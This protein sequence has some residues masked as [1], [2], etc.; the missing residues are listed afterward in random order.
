MG[1][2]LQCFYWD[3]PRE[4]GKEYAWW[5]HLKA[6]MGEIA[7]AGF[8]SLWLPPAG[9]AANIGG[10]SM[11]YDVYD[12]FD[13]GKHPQKAVVPGEVRTWFGSEEE[14]KALIVAA[15]ASKLSVYAD[16][17][18]NHNNGADAL[19]Y[20]PILK[21]ERWTRFTPQS[22]RFP[23]DWTCFHPTP[24]EY[25]GDQG[26]F[27]DMPDLCHINPRVSAAIL[28]HTRWM[29]EEIGFDGFRY[30]YVKGFS[31]WVIRAIHDM[32]YVRGGEKLAIFGVGE[33]WDSDFAIDGWLDSVN[34]YSAHQAAAFDFPFR[35]RLKELCDSDGY[36]L[37]SLTA[38]GVLMRDRPFE[39]VTFVDNHDFRGEFPEVARDKMLAYAVILTHEGYPCV[40]WKD[41]FTYG[42]GLPGEP[43]GIE[44]LVQLHERYA[45]GPSTTLFLDDGCYVLQRDG[46]AGQAGLVLVLNAGSDWRRERVRCRWGGTR[47]VPRAWRG[48]DLLFTPEAATTDAAGWLE[49]AAPPRGYVVYVPEG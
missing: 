44:R 35:Y 31:G 22:G 26:R 7:G 18:I 14:L 10:M 20:N 25:D 32:E 16:L 33:C 17:V 9:K 23:R 48:R 41:Y 34:A 6:R 3:C 2:M 8:T 21:T 36:S 43:S 4:E 11:G 45:G 19:E 49:V 15:H 24:Y 13:L 38:G 29:I 5:N 37:R 12:Y 28:H 47:L 39:A 46:I 42:L 27:G 40:F 1:V 30:D